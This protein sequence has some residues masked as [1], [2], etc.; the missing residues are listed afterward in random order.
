MP[1]GYHVSPSMCLHAHLAIVPNCAPI[2]VHNSSSR[3]APRTSL[4]AKSRFGQRFLGGA[5]SFSFCN[6]AWLHFKMLQ[7]MGGSRRKVAT[8]RKSTQN[9]QK[10]YFEQRKRRQQLSSGSENCYD[11][12]DTGKEQKEHRSLDIISF[13]NLSTIPQENKAAYTIE[14]NGETGAPSG[15]QEKTLS[16]VK[17]VISDP[18]NG[19][20][21]KNQVDSQS[22]QGKSCHGLSIFDL[23]GDDGMAVKCEGSPMKETHVA[24]SVDGL[25][26][27]GMETPA[28]SPQHGSRSF[29]YGFSSRLERMRPWNSSKNT[30]VLDDFGLEGDIIMQDIKMHLD[31]GSLN[32]SFDMMDTCDNPKEKKPTKTHFCSVEDCKR[33]EHGGRSIFDDMDGERDGYEGGFNF[34]NNNFLGEMEC[35]RFEKTR[36]NEIGGVSCD[37]LNYEKYDISENAFDSPYLPKKR[38]AGVPRTM[39]RFN[40]FD[41]VDPSSKHHT[42]GYDYD[43]MGD[44]KRNLKATRIS[45]FE[46]KS[47]QPDW[48]CSM[49][50]DATDN[51]SLLSEESC[52]TSAVRDEAFNSTPLNSN[53]RHSMRRGMDDDGSGPGNSYRVSSIYSRDPYHKIEDE[54]QK[55]YVRKSNSSKFKPVHHSNSPFMEKPQPLKTWSF[56]NECN[57]SSPC[58]SPVAH[59]P[60]KG[61]T[62]WNEYPC[63]ESSLPESSFTNKHVETVP[64]PSSSSISKKPSFQPSN[65]PIAVLER[66]LCSNSKFVGTHTSLTETTSSLGEDPISPVLSAQGSVGTGEKSES[67]VPSIGSEKVDF[68]EDKCTRTRSKKVCVDDSNR[69]WLNDSNHEKKNCDSFR[70]ETENGSL[71]VKNLVASHDSD[72][73]ENDGKINKF[74]PDDKVSVPYSKGDKEVK[75]VKV[76]GRK[77]RSK[78][79]SMDSSS[80]VMMLESYV[81]QLLF[82]QKVLLKQ[83]SSQDFMKNA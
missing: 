17:H 46:D 18:N 19:N 1:D 34:L 25:G 32:Y 40:L 41:A 35:D 59:R 5:A 26:R 20:N 65:I 38:G 45:D 6:K 24:F 60:F 48:F 78:S 42:L 28:C 62:P 8:S 11:A 67:K 53:P 70:N 54:E 57:F 37:F 39:D 9:R 76:E 4:L 10:Q 73:I 33:K 77:T 16:P 12:S 13:L 80:Q 15:Y 51:F 50:D 74:S 29:S 3:F 68:H 56:E 55:K 47:H 72:H 63:A 79:C 7:W 64:H 81:L 82:V 36:F 43:L 22:D 2:S 14:Q 71:A 27:V 75:D 66:S 69:E 44:V 83:A 31:D 21:A 30:K 61:S 58:Q 52:A 49:A 23:L